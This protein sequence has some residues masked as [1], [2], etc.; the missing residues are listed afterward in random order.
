VG[1]NKGF[2]PEEVLDAA[3]DLFWRRGYE[4]TSTAELVAETGVARGSLY[5]TFH[6]KHELYLRTLDRYVRAHYWTLF[7][8]LRSRPSPV[9]PAVRTL[10]ETYAAAAANGCFVVNAAV[11]RMGDDEVA[12]MVRLSWQNLEGMLTTALSRAQERG[13]LP[14]D[15]EPDA[16]ARFLMVFLQ[17]VRVVGVDTQNRERL[18][19]AVRIALKI[20]D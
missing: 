15:A 7:T 1:R 4:A 10:V 14:T 11:E 18:A 6:S 9:L 17:G 16:L 20:L 13:E 2:D 12:R 3:L 8:M 19:D 5:A